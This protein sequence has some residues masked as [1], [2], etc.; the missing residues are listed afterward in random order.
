MCVVYWTRKIKQNKNE[1]LTP[2]ECQ[3]NTS[4]SFETIL[5][6]SS[7]RCN[8]NAKRFNHEEYETGDEKKQPNKTVISTVVKIT[9]VIYRPK[10]LYIHLY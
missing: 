6:I 10:Q 2:I 7:K 4:R 8:Q 3:E 1:F 9:T 5:A